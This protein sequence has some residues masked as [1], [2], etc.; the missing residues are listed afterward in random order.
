MTDFRSLFDKEFL[1]SWDLGEKDRIVVIER[2]EAKKIKGASGDE[3]RQPVVY[4][5][6][7]KKGLVCNV[8]NAKT[9]AKLYGKHVEKW[10]GKPVALYATRTLAFG[11]EVDCIRVRPEAPEMPGPGEVAADVE[12]AS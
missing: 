12:A 9:I 7:K 5:K 8:T 3:K 4:F 1:G 10:A 11:E 2:V 6:G